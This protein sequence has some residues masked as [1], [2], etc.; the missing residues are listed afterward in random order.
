VIHWCLGFFFLFFFCSAG[1]GAQVF[2][3]C[4]TS[5]LPLACLG[6]GF[7]LSIRCCYAVPQV[8]GPLPAAPSALPTEMLPVGSLLSGPGAS[9]WRAHGAHSEALAERI[10]KD[11]KAGSSRG[12]LDKVCSLTLHT[13]VVQKGS[14][15]KADP[16]L[17]S[18]PHP[19]PVSFLPAFDKAQS[20]SWGHIAS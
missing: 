8:E 10:V 2:C 1:V 3:I 18:P 17:A 16:S 4:W 11:S 14:Q 15:G 5:S 13:S 12:W 6:L 20:E 7:H 19:Q 9:G